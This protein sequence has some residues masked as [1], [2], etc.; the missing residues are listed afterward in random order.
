MKGVII[1]ITCLIII[2]IGW[3]VFYYFSI[4]DTVNYYWDELDKL[5]YVVEDE[6][7]AEADSM[8]ETYL[9]KW[10]QT[11]NLWIYF[12][13]QDNVN[14]IDVSISRLKDYISNKNVILSQSEMEELK[15][16]FNFVDEN[17]CLSWE[18]IF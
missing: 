1:S 14:Q 4:E 16:K 17:E 2:I 15:C 12:L 11:R 6:K 3:G 18:N 8:M 7:W 9:E 13:N 5:A 10:E